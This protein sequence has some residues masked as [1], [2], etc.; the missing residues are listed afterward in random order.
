MY[1]FTAPQKVVITQLGYDLSGDFYL[2]FNSLLSRL[3]DGGGGG[4]MG[5]CW[6]TRSVFLFQNYSLLI[7]PV[8]YLV[9][10]SLESLVL[11]IDRVFLLLRSFTWLSSRPF[12]FSELARK[13]LFFLN[14]VQDC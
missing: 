11:E 8:E 6:I 14:N 5:G 9:F 13:F 3:R 2:L 7:I 10:I 1:P 4:G 12:R